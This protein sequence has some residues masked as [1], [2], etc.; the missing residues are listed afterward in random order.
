[1]YATSVITDPTEVVA[2]TPVGVT[3]SSLPSPQSAIPQVNLPQPVSLNDSVSP[4]EVVAT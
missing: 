2:D 1:V 4:K 3:N